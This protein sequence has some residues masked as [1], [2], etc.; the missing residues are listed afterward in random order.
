[1]ATV[2]QRL[3]HPVLIV[4]ICSAAIVACAVGW[5]EQLIVTVVLPDPPLYAWRL[6]RPEFET[7]VKL[8]LFEPGPLKEILGV[9]NNPHGA[10]RYQLAPDPQSMTPVGYCP[11]NGLLTCE[12]LSKVMV[13][14]ARTTV[15]AA[16]VLCVRLALVPVTVRV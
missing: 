6:A 13:V 1:M 14:E 2:E 16:L 3:V 11:V 10:E 9:V 4:T 12:R 15:S 7:K 8:A 5:P